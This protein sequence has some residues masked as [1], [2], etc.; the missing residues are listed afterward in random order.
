MSIP[1]LPPPAGDRALLAG[2][3][4][5]LFFFVKS[6]LNGEN[7]KEIREVL[8]LHNRDVRERGG[9]LGGLRIKE[10]ENVA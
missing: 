7:A 6:S 10:R 4:L 5:G 9:V 2:W 3:Y 1:E 8:D